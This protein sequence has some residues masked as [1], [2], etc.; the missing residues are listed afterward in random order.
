MQTNLV[1]KLL[2]RVADA[3]GRIWGVSRRYKS[4]S[5][6]HVVSLP[7]RLHPKPLDFSQGL[8]QANKKAM[9]VQAVHDQI[10]SLCVEQ[11][12]PPLTAPKR[13]APQACACVLRRFPS[14][15]CDSHLST[16][17]QL[18]QNIAH[19]AMP[20]NKKRKEDAFTPDFRRRQRDA[21]S[22]TP[23]GSARSTAAREVSPEL[24]LIFLNDLLP[25]T[26]D[27]TQHPFFDPNDFT[28]V[29][30]ACFSITPYT[31]SSKAA[32]HYIIPE[33]EMNRRHDNDIEIS[34]SAVL[35]RLHSQSRAVKNSVRAR[36]NY[37]PRSNF[38]A[39]PSHLQT[40]FNYIPHPNF[41]ADPSH[42]QMI[43][44]I[45]SIEIHGDKAACPSQPPHASRAPV[46]DDL[47]CTFNTLPK[48][49]QPTILSIKIGRAH[50]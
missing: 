14:L 40:R 29:N 17:T 4:N 43:G 30:D 26:F 48:W 11:N 50:V 27:D 47:S 20:A 31:F 18:A 16:R 34:H 21:A 12:H 15:P 44:I 33:E 49:I 2:A 35:A 45:P 1:N 23:Q 10:A 8:T 3:R 9:R 7:V 28:F 5:N 19:S 36:F 46:P 13:R 24:G 6:P 38:I 37:I 42:L 39:D 22:R 25:G 41:I 32:P